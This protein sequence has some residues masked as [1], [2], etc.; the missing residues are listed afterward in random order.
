MVGG[1]GK[2]GTFTELVQV[3]FVLE[4]VLRR[5]GKEARKVRVSASLQEN[6]R[7]ESQRWSTSSRQRP[8]YSLLSRCL[9]FNENQIKEEQ[10]K[11]RKNL[12]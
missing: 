3:S 9:I 4:C 5:S 11:K 8:R 10:T 7:V 6:H 12:I 1:G 2:G